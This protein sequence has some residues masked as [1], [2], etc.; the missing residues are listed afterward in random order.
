MSLAMNNT[1]L[2]NSNCLYLDKTIC[3]KEFNGYP[4]AIGNN[5]GFLNMMRPYNDTASFEATLEALSNGTITSHY[6]NSLYGCKLGDVL[7][8]RVDNLRYQRSFFCAKFVYETLEQKLCSLPPI[9]GDVKL[10]PLGPGLCK[11]QCN[12]V[13]S[14]YGSIVLDRDVCAGPSGNLSVNLNF[15]NRWT[16]LCQSEN[17]VT[18]PGSCSKGSVEESLNCGEFAEIFI[19]MNIFF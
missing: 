18:I 1:T 5:T 8:K 9:Q 19:A 4:V 10:N 13:V 15:M 7:T 11:E 17:A 16:N 6:L 3:G 2:Q 14:Q 12:I